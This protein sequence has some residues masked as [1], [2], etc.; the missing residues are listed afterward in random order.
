[1]FFI[2]LAIRATWIKAGMVNKARQETL[3]K[4]KNFHRVGDKGDV[5]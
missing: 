4:K 5:D 1:M 3:A 2:G